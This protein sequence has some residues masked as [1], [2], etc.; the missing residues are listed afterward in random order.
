MFQS[1][2]YLIWLLLFIA[3]PLLVLSVLGRGALVRRRRALVL[4]VVG[5]L[6]SGW[7]WDAAAVHIGLWFYDPANIVGV[8]F[9]GL[10]LEEWLWIVGVTLLFGSLT[11][12]LKAREAVPK[13]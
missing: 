13:P 2:T 7:L 5:A 12:V 8:W 11:V 4:A 6:V 9:L 3:L 10:P 1:A